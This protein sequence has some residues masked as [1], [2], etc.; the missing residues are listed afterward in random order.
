MSEYSPATATHPGAHPRTSAPTHGS[1]PPTNHTPR[2]ST[3]STLA[4]VLP[5]ILPHWE[6]ETHNLGSC[7]LSVSNASPTPHQED[8]GK[9]YSKS[10]RPEYRQQSYQNTQH[11]SASLTPRHPLRVQPTPALNFTDT[12]SPP[13]RALRRKHGLTHSAIRC[14]SLQLLQLSRLLPLPRQHGL[15]RCPPAAERAE[16]PR[17]RPILLVL[18]AMP[19]GLA[20]CCF[21]CLGG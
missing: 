3:A 16:L 10:G 21:L 14:C 12:T 13:P 5:K 2:P 6:E 18:G 1:H 4:T 19:A 11:A 7:L 15:V 17:P 8:F 20:C 9:H